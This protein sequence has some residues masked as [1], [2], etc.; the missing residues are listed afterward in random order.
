MLSRKELFAAVN[1]IE[2]AVTALAAYLPPPKLVEIGGVRCY[3]HEGQDDRLLCFMKCVRASSSLNACLV[4]LDHGFVF[5]VST[6][7]R[8]IDECCQDICFL[9]TAQAA[10]SEQQKMFKAFFEE[11]QDRLAVLLTSTP[12]PDSVKRSKVHAA[13]AR[14][15]PGDNPSDIQAV[16]GTLHRVSSGYVHSAYPHLMELYRGKP[17]RFHLRGM[18]MTPKVPQTQ[19][20]LANSV[21]RTIASVKIVARR[22]NAA[23]VYEKLRQIQTALEPRL[24]VAGSAEESRKQV[25]RLKGKKPKA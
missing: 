25:D 13:L 10:R 6:L 16:W 24:G 12:G 7:C 4:L 8:C 9:S 11:E 14:A 19:K 20:S 21:Y 2:Q 22:L 18:A 1:T 5:E 17:P 3:R 15:G 23:D